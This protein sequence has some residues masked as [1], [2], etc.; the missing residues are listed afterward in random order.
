MARNVCRVRRFV[1]TCCGHRF[2]ASYWATKLMDSGQR[3]ETLGDIRCPQCGSHKLSMDD[4]ES[5]MSRSRPARLPA[6]MRPVVYRWHDKEGK[7]RFRYPAHADPNVI[8]QR[9]GE[10][11]VE[12]DTLRSMEQFL[13]QQN[14]GYRDWQMPLNDILDYDHAHIDIPALDTTDPGLAA[15]ADE[16]ESAILEDAGV[17]TEAEV[18]EFMQRTD[19]LGLIEQA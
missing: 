14:P 1:C 18:Q 11:R 5:R 2:V 17:A 15:E 6:D 19:G 16:L 9:A 10:E 7:E 12:F 13:I 3:F 8:Q 4:F